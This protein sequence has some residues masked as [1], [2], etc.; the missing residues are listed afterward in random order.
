MRPYD[1]RFTALLAHAARVFAGR[2]YDRTSM[3]DLAA[4][5]RR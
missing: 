2:G 1:E 3:R 5:D 4:D